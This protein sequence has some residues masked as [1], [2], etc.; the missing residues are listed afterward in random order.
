MA[1]TLVHR[2]QWLHLDVG[3]FLLFHPNVSSPLD[4]QDHQQHQV[5]H[6]DD[7]LGVLHLVRDLELI[8]LRSFVESDGCEGLNR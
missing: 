8:I 5:E 7:N 4:C 6:D 2:P 3:F 1:L